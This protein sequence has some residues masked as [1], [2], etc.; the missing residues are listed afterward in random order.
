M[1]RRQDYR[2]SDPP[3]NTV[4][5]RRGRAGGARTTLDNYTRSLACNARSPAHA[6]VCHR[7]IGTRISGQMADPQCSHDLRG[8]PREWSALKVS[9]T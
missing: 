6:T 1:V 8:D 5:P 2:G 3:I 4:S 7:G 9:Q